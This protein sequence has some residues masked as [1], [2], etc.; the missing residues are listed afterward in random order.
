[1]KNIILIV[2]SPIKAKTIQKLGF[3]AVA[4]YGHIKDLPVKS[5]GVDL[6]TFSPTY[7]FLRGKKKLVEKIKKIVRGKKTLIATDPDREGEAIAKFVAEELSLKGKVRVRIPAITEADIANYIKSPQT[8]D[9]SLVTSQKTRR[10]IDRLIGYL[11]SPILRRRIKLTNSKLSLS[12]GRVQTALL[13]LLA[14]H[15]IKVAKHGKKKQYSYSFE[16]S[17]LKF[18]ATHEEKLTFPPQLAKFQIEEKNVK[19]SPPTPLNTAALQKIAST[20]GISP[21]QTMK[22][23]Q[24]L[25]ETGFITYHRTSE[26]AVSESGL[27]LA[28]TLLKENFTH[29]NYG[30]VTTHEAIRPTSISAITSSSRLYGPYKK[31]FSTIKNHFLAAFMPDMEG[32]LLTLKATLK[33][34]NPHGKEIAVT[35]TCKLFKKTKA[36][37][38]KYVSS[39]FDKLP[40]LT[41][42]NKKAIDK[43]I[44][45]GLQVDN[46]S[47]KETI[48]TLPRITI[49]GC[50]QLMEKHG[51][52]RPSTY[53][54]AIQNLL[55]RKFIE[56]LRRSNKQS[57]ESKESKSENSIGVTPLGMLIY[58]LTKNVHFL[59]PEY[60]KNM[61]D[62]LDRIESMNDD[63]AQLESFAILYKTLED[64]RSCD[65]MATCKSCGSAINF[66]V[67]TPKDV[68]IICPLCGSERFKNT[69]KLILKSQILSL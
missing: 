34:K 43:L 28:S 26:V 32:K 29:R 46:V 17:T 61:E 1:M 8:I 44:N 13:H 52:G 66:K 30:V 19:L 63:K 25:F 7:F 48:K 16:V 50:V 15:E 45:N 54:Y 20:M 31:I 3:K 12:A 47:H 14:Q 69:E 68:E 53:A 37:W 18:T 64:I 65:L 59:L 21:T 38:T 35:F 40:K 62:K 56:K 36:G 9:L 24:F 23:A 60:T 58:V 4:T 57:S 2:E 49:R 51:I 55:N 67:N 11:V 10:L 22:I 6:K 41:S 42:E 39:F 5:L 27:K 33:G